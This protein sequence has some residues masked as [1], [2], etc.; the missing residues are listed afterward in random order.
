MLHSH[1][2]LRYYDKCILHCLQSVSACFKWISIELIILLKFASKMGLI[3]YN[4]C[5]THPT[6]LMWL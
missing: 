3:F 4:E 1:N 6:E 5:V 2:I